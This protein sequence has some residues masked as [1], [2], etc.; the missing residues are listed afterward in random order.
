[1]TKRKKRPVAPIYSIA[2]VWVV[3]TLVHPLYRV[4]DYVSVILLSAVVFIIAKGIWPTVEYE[5]PDPA[6]ADGPQ[7][8]TEANPSQA[9][10][11]AHTQ[12]EP[13]EKAEEPAEEPPKDDAKTAEDPAEP[14]ANAAGVD[15]EARQ[16]AAEDPKIAILISE[17]DLALKEM[18]R[19]NDAIDDPF[20]SERIEQ[21]QTVTAKI[22]DHVIE[23]PEKHRQIRRF[24]N[25][26]LPTTLKILN[27]YDRMG[28]AGVSG[29]NIDTTMDRIETMLN[30]IVSS[31]NKQLDALFQDE[32]MDIAS[33]ITVMEQLLEQEG[34]R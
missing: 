17:K 20:V 15:D 4:S 2:V 14:D 28:A 12:A 25:Y 22:I 7:A 3:F 29:E 18:I 11:E 34:L 26:Y 10:A 32:A 13:E 23:H 9:D 24:M 31:F 1:M 5:I 33:D 16:K 19:L 21:L 27:A 6:G 8:D 30:T